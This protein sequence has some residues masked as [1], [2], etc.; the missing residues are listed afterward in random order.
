M[1]QDDQQSPGYDYEPPGVDHRALPVSVQLTN[2]EEYFLRG[3]FGQGGS[4]VVFRVRDRNGHQY[5]AKVLTEKASRHSIQ[6]ELE[7]YQR[8][9]QNPHINLLTLHLSEKLLNPSPG[10]RD[11]VFITEACGPSIKDIMMRA[12]RDIGNV[13][14]PTFSINAIKSIGRQVGEALFHLEKLK[15]YHLDIK[16]ANVTFMSTVKYDVDTNLAQPSITMNDLQIKLIDYGNSLPHS[17]PGIPEIY[18]LVQPQNLRAPEIFMGI[19]HSEKTD[20]WSMGCLM[21]QMY[22][23]KLIFMSRTGATQIEIQQSQFELIVNRMNATIPEE[24]IEMSRQG[25]KCTLDLNFLTNR[26]GNNH[27]DF[28]LNLMRDMSDLPLFEF[29][30]FVLVFNPVERPSFEELLNHKFLAN[31]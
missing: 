12:K 2:Y 21:G 23:G 10:Y 24:M 26:D 4:S 15:I 19:P 16:S 22:L 30:L 25:R 9:A 18:K 6:R 8:S 28:L 3:V 1:Q 7:T 31:C 17:T 29:L 11:D 5:A 20:V 14:S 27:Q 13:Q